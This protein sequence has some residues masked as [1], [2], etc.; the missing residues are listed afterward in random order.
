VEIILQLII[1]IIFAYLISGF[2]QL[3]KDMN[4][5]PVDA[6]VWT[7]NPTA[8]M[9]FFVFF[10]WPFIQLLRYDELPGERARAIA[11]A[12]LG[13]LS[14]MVVL[15]GFIFY[16]ISLATYLVDSL[17]LQ[18]IISAAI[19]FIGSMFVLPLLTL[20]MMPV[21]LLLAWPLDILFPPKKK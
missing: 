7:Y 19:I 16:S 14:Q 4:A 8:K 1:S 20:A 18:I 15:T 13:I 21:M 3:S 12:L 11:H 10:G 5:N 9:T 6:P 17:W 2:A